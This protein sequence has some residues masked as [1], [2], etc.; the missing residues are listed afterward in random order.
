[1][2]LQTIKAKLTPTEQAKLQA[3]IDT[4]QLEASLHWGASFALQLLEMAF[5]NYREKRDKQKN[6]AVKT[7]LTA[8]GFNL[9]N[10]LTAL[11]TKLYD[12]LD[13]KS[14]KLSTAH[15]FRQ[16]LTEVK[17]T[18]A[19]PYNLAVQGM[20]ERFFRDMCI[21][22]RKHKADASILDRIFFVIPRNVVKEYINKLSLDFFTNT[23][24]LNIGS[25]IDGRRATS[26]DNDIVEAV[27]DYKEIIDKY[28]K[29][30]RKLIL[31]AF[32]EVFTIFKDFQSVVSTPKPK[33][34]NLEQQLDYFKYLNSKPNLT[35]KEQQHLKLLRKSKFTV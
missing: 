10:Q 24:M 12:D 14:K 11:G 34:M 25:R 32:K 15:P 27:V 6:T 8:T 1:M 5:V 3:A 19:Q 26:T 16:C 35:K 31:K 30:A 23:A 7:R 20:M 33:K 22:Y 21:L 18:D 29:K 4:V 9:A 28:N 17:L 2:Q 13:K